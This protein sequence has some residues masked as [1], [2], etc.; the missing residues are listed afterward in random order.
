MGTSVGTLRPRYEELS[1]N[2]GNENA[3]L[4]FICKFACKQIIKNCD[5]VAFFIDQISKDV[6]IIILSISN[7]MIRHTVSCV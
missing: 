6:N 2:G 4:P 7:F 1:Y 5:E 3:K